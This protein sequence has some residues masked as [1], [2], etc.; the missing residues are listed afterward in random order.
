M[1]VGPFVLKL[2]GCALTDEGLGSCGTVT[3]EFP[4]PCQFSRDRSGGVSHRFGD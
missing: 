1:T 2:A 3:F 4:E